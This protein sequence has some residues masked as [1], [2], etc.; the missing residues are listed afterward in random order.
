MAPACRSCLVLWTRGGDR[1]R[2]GARGPAS[3]TSP[4]AVAASRWR[5]AVSARWSRSRSTSLG[6]EFGQVLGHVDAALVEV[7]ILNRLT[8]LPRAE[9]DRDGRLLAGR[10]VV[11]PTR[12]QFR[13]RTLHAVR[14]ARVRDGAGMDADEVVA[15]LFTA[16]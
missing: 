7:E 16:R 4:S 12:R 5:A 15:T 11:S 6:G 3:A 1:H 14:R 13:R 9:D 10:P 2:S 8:L